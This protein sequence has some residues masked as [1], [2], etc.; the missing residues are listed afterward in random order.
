MCKS[1][2]YRGASQWHMHRPTRLEAIQAWH[3]GPRP[4][5]TFDVC[6]CSEPDASWPSNAS[7]SDSSSLADFFRTRFDILTGW[8]WKYANNDSLIMHMSIPKRA[9]VSMKFYLWS[10]L[11]WQCSLAN[12]DKTLMKIPQ[13]KHS[14]MHHAKNYLGDKKLG[15]EWPWVELP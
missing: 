2:I 15:M 5:A 12:T 4:T 3:P 11:F 7:C 14:L 6:T 10:Q 8:N 13:T 1:I 9:C